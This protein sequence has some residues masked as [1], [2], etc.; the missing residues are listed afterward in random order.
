MKLK[1]RTFK[2]L[3]VLTFFC[4]LTIIVFIIGER[5]NKTFVFQK[6]VPWLYE[7]FY[8]EKDFA[9]LKTEEELKA[10][11]D[12]IIADVFPVFVYDTSIIANFR[13]KFTNELDKIFL[14]N[15]T[16]D[17]EKHGILKI[18]SEIFQYKKAVDS[19]LNDSYYNIGVIDSIVL[20]GGKPIEKI[21]IYNG[22]YFTV[23]KYSDFLT[24]QI[25]RN[26]LLKIHKRPIFKTID[27][28]V[29]Q[30][31]N[32][33]IQTY[34]FPVVYRYD[35]SL[36]NRI[37]RNKINSISPYYGMVK[38]GELIIK[39]GSLVT[40][41]EYRIL[42]TM[43]K[44]SESRFFKQNE[45]LIYLGAVIIFGVI[46]TILIYY[47]MF[48][49]KKKIKKLRDLIFVSVT[50]I[51]QVISV[52]LVF[53]Y[54]D[55]KIEIIPYALFPLLLLSFYSFHVSFVFYLFSVIIS[56]FFASNGFEFML[57]QL[58]AGTV[59]MFSLKIRNRRSQIFKTVLFVIGTYFF[60]NLGF[61][62]MKFEVPQASDL[63]I[64]IPYLISSFLI[65]LYFPF[66]FI[67]EKLF[68]FISDYT[69]LELS[70]TNNPL[71]RE[72]SEK[73]PGTF[74]HSVQLAN[75]VELVVRELKGNSLLARTGALY[76]DIG[77]MVHPEYYIENQTGY[78]I[79]DDLDYE[80]SAQK[81][82]SHVEDGVK[83]AK[84]HKL[85]EQIIDFIVMHHGTSMTKYFY[86]MWVNS[87]PGIAP[88]ESNF[89]YPGPKP[90]SLETAVLMMADGLEAASRT[91]KEY[92]KES[93]ENLVNNIIDNQIKSGQFDDV[94]LTFKEISTAKK[95]FADKIKSV[96]HGRIIYPEIE[97]NN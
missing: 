46:F 91:L 26:N 9:I 17:Q 34:K 31:L 10:E 67:V 64:F 60:L 83:L 84:K 57:I 8:A 32:K 70:D 76:H 85:P 41:N 92:S 87:N 62:L 68:G 51:S 45:T 48:F 80:V 19:L 82:I 58:I 2:I 66:L 13:K 90:N 74:Q 56:S 39:H 1:N 77:K 35:D 71:L 23:A 20:I 22:K 16:K 14:I 79:H 12:S 27:S 7:D 15:K 93:I 5:T 59:A 86:N 89:R 4:L 24:Q 18:S 63:K 81:I 94:D 29:S 44:E 50:M 25:L 78:N 95:I 33:I 65:L 72:L 75:I 3:T 88:V 52:F 69:L 37:I 97:K 36:T 11:Q 38:K 40:D 28:L 47:I 30:D 49:Q 54:T 73:A 21:T 43:I 6:G 55:L 53:K 96:F 61:L 42:N